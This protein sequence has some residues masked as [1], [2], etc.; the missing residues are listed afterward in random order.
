MPND[1]KRLENIVRV[2]EPNDLDA[3][4]KNIVKASK[5]GYPAFDYGPSREIAQRVLNLNMTP[6][7]IEAACDSQNKISKKQN[8]EA[9]LQ[10]LKVG[11]KL[12]GGNIVCHQVKKGL[13]FRYKQG[14]MA[15]L[16]PP[17]FYT[18]DGKVFIPW[19]QFSRGFHYTPFHMALI[20]TLLKREYSEYFDDPEIVIVDLSA[21][22]QSERAARVILSSEIEL[23]SDAQVEAA[24]DLYIRADAIAQEIVKN[25][26]KKPK[27][28]KVKKPNPQQPNMFD[29]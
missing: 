13:E 26:P 8:T 2:I 28:E 23:L 7:H 16:K 6:A 1:T 9:S 4:V 21:D 15:I 10:L 24:F 12:Q 22:K 19:I 20:A 17:F 25:Q 5:E 27:K 11:K 18:N 29:Q 14:H 3:T